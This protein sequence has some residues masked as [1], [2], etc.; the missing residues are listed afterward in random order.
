LA[1]DPVIQPD[2]LEGSPMAGRTMMSSTRR[3]PGLSLVRLGTNAAPSI[4]DD[5]GRA[6]VFAPKLR[7]P[8]LRAGMVERPRLT[9]RLAATTARLV[10][11]SAPPGF[12]KSTLLAQW[13]AVDPRRFAFVL[14]EPSENDPVELWNCVVSSIRQVEPSFGASVQAMLHSV[15]GIAIDALVRRIATGIE[16][17]R[18]PVV[19]VLD[20]Y[21]VI[22]N[23]ACHASVEALIAHPMRQ[24]LLVVST[25]SDPTVR[26]GRLRASGE[27]LEIRGG[28]LAFTSHETEELLHG[29]I[30]F[31][32][33]DDELE[34]LQGRTEGWPAGLQLASLGLRTSRDRELFLRSFGGSNRHV[35]DYL[36][37]VVLDSVDDDVR[38]FLLETSILSQLSGPLCDAVTGR[39]GGAAMLDMLE[40]MNLFVISLDDQRLWY[41]YHNLF[42]EL[43]GDQLRLA[44]PARIAELHRTASAWFAEAGDV[45]Q[46]I[47]HAI[48][49]GEFDAATRIVAESWVVRAAS[50]RLATVLAWLDAFPDGYV[51]TNAQ[52]SLIKAWAMGVLGREAEGRRC[53]ED[54]LRTGDNKPL[55]DGSGTVEQAAA[56]VRSVFPWGDVEQLYL[57]GRAVKEA[58]EAFAP[59]FQPWASFGI[60]MGDFF[61]GDFEEA[62]TEL[63][64]AASQATDV[65]ASGILV[66][67]QGLLTQIDLAENRIEEAVDLG[68]RLVDWARVHGF[69]DLPH[70]GYHLAALGMAIARSGRLD[71]GDELLR[72]GIAQSFDFDP[73][74]A[75]HARLMRAP[76][77]RQLGDIDGARA[78]LDEAKLLLAQCAGT[79]IIGELAAQVARTL[80]TSRRRGEERTDLTDRELDVLRLLGRGLSK[81]AIAKELF[82]SFHTVHS[83]TKSIYLRLGV[84][85]REAA[86]ERAHDLELL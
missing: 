81:R 33:S 25:R 20:D 73:L 80:S 26:L 78:L 86:I 10:L 8:V 27:L 12:G 42:A 49:A 57:A 66:N 17:L 56:L 84:S 29:T 41:R 48:D 74:L 82:V 13:E 72:S 69:S 39:E 62:R 36:A 44:M 83:H 7:P 61:V 50:G 43:L 45:G 34:L 35:V 47:R 70:M 51:R 5:A 24:A 67:V 3:S 21:H 32:L 19:V 77:R 59:I 79:G 18:Q 54:A 4:P 31:Q 23:P 85:S 16:E 6:G 40:R 52:L 30:G 14:L 9:Q 65:D 76:V 15:G 64:R 1:E 63:E 46:A 75:A 37:E 55:P 68:Q 11:V 22:R 53:I 60:G 2:N 28:D 71:E 38:E 58:R